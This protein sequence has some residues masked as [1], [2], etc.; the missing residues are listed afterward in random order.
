M[1]KNSFVM[2]LA[3]EMH[4]EFKAAYEPAEDV[5]WSPCGSSALLNV[6]I[7]SR[8][9]MNNA[10]KAGSILVDGMTMQIQWRKC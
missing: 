3:G 7:E 6:K 10:A 2:T 4:E 8:F 5:A 1:Q 9:D